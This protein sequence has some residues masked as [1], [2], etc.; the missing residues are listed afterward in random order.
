[1][2]SSSVVLRTF[3][4]HLPLLLYLFIA[5][6]KF[7]GRARLDNAELL[8]R[9]IQK[10]FEKPRFPPQIPDPPVKRLICTDLRVR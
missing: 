7:L 8:F 4:A 9:D 5:L 2:S 10:H 6:L 1:M 3:A